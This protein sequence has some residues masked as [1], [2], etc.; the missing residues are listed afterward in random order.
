MKTGPETKEETEAESG[1]EIEIATEIGIEIEDEAVFL[2]C[3][4]PPTQ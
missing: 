4:S 1:T 3:Q 2:A